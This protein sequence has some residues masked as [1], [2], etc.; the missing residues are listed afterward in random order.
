MERLPEVTP[1]SGLVAVLTGATRTRRRLTSSSSA[2]I[3]ARAV[4]TPWPYSTLPEKIV[5]TPGPVKSSQAASTGLAARVTGS[6]EAGGDGEIAEAGGTGGDPGGGV[7]IRWPA[8]ARSP[9]SPP[10]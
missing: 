5:T 2:A 7:V 4:H 1:S 3:W 8:P 6:G 9:R 10:S